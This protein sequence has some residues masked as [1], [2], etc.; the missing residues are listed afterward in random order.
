MTNIKRNF[1]REQEAIALAKVALGPWKPHGDI[2]P[3]RKSAPPPK[4]TRPEPVQQPVKPAAET[5]GSLL[6]AAVHLPETIGKFDLT[7]PR[8]KRALLRSDRRA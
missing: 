4:P 1:E 6:A 3:F 7:D 5:L 8:Y 2:V